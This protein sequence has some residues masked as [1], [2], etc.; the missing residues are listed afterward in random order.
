MFLVHQ[1]APPRVRYLHKRATMRSRYCAHEPPLP[2]LARGPS[3][4]EV[5]VGGD[6]CRAAIPPALL[7]GPLPLCRVAKYRRLA[8]YRRRCRLV[9]V[10]GD[11]EISLS[12]PPL[13]WV[14]AISLWPVDLGE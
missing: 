3:N 11:L 5:L 13:P 10:V 7:G 8:V 9:S 1:G 2:P 12:L 6:G 14:S 4:L